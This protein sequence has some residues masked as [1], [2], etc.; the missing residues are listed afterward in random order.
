MV[1]SGGEMT[2]FLKCSSCAILLAASLTTSATA[3]DKGFALIHQYS[4]GDF[5]H[6]GVLVQP[7]T[8]DG[9]MKGKLFGKPVKAP[10]GLHILGVYIEFSIEPEN[11]LL[12]NGKKYGDIFEFP[13]KLEAG[14]SY[15]TMGRQS[16]SFVEVWVID[17]QTQKL[18]SEVVEIQVH[19]CKPFKFKCPMPTITK[20]S[21][22]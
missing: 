4:N 2:R 5:W 22:L 12:G 20:R 16:G 18:V 3:Q 11:I 19:K 21:E 9:K 6:S 17:N 8:I 10:A 13:L 14:H 15:K 7:R 1:E